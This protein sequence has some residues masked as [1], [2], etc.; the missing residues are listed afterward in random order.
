LNKLR[1]VT[2]ITND[3]S[4]PRRARIL[5]VDDEFGPRESLR[6]ILRPTYEVLTASDGSEALE[7]LRTN[8][9]DLVTLDLNMPGLQGEEL[10]RVIRREFQAVEVIVITGYGS[11][12]SAVEG[13]RYGICD[14]IQKPFDVVKVLSAVTRGLGS[15]QGRAQLTAFLERL[16]QLVGRAEDVHRILGQIERSPRLQRRVDGLLAVLEDGRPAD[17]GERV[18]RATFLEVLAETIECQQDFMRGHAQ[19]TSFYSGLLSDRLCLSA[20]DQEHVRLAGFLH[21]VGKVGVP[22]ELLARAGALDPQERRLIERHPV[23]GVGLVEPLDLASEVTMAIRHHHEWWDGRGYPDGLFGSQI[24]LAARIV[25]IADAYDAMTSDRPY[26]KA[27]P[28]SVAQDELK[29]FAGVQ[30]DPVLVKEFLCILETSDVDLQLLAES[31]PDELGPA[32][33]ARSL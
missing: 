10:M 13:L 21:D 7:I 32:A 4:E 19:R 3:G 27:L 33:A 2:H 24:S 25:A 17:E 16:G 23:I 12:D 1:P 6:M 29:T 9:I 11:V 22:S 18:R 20:R 8:A 30:F 28:Q 14:Y 5:V 15:R 26:R 31:V